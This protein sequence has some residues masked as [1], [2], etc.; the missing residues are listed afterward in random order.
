MVLAPSLAGQIAGRGGRAV[1]AVTIWSGSGNSRARDGELQ[2]M[3]DDV[4]TRVSQ[5]EFALRFFVVALLVVATATGLAE[6]LIHGVGRR[7]VAPW[8]GIPP[9]FWLTTV[10]LIAGSSFLQHALHQ[11]RLERQ[12]RFRRSLLAALATG[13]AF[14]GLQGYGL[15]CLAQEQD[16]AEVAVSASMFVLVFAALHVLHFTVAMLFLVFVTLNGFSDR[17]DHEYYWG[18]T[19]CTY[20]WHAL[21]MIWLCILCVFAIA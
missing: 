11:V 15:W 19:V 21:A 13:T 12:L 2:R 20:F 9:V 18:V 14:V 8:P 7:E 16:P 4:T 6:G 17:Y 10:L 3:H 1:V 5:S